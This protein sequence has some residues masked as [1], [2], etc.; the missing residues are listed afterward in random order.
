MSALKRLGALGCVGLIA[1]T[2][3]CS[4]KSSGPVAGAPDVVIRVGSANAY[5][6]LD[7]AHAY[8]NGAWTVYYNVYQRLLSYRPGANLP[9]EDAAKS[10]V[11]TDAGDLTYKCVLRP[12]M[13][14]WN[15]DPLDAAAVKYSIDRV[16]KINDQNG[17]VAILSSTIKS[18]E[19]QGSD[20]VLFHLKDPDATMPDRLSSGVASIIDPKTLPAT[21]EAAPDF[22]GVV[23]SGRYKID[24]VDFTGSGA[25]KAPS[26]MKLSL[27]PNYQG[28]DTPPRNSGVDVKYFPDQTGTKKALDANQVDAVIA[29]LNTS[30]VIHMQ[31]TQQL[32]SGL[33]VAS[34]PGGGINMMAL[35]T[36]SGVFAKPAV[37]RAVAQLIDR[38]A[39]VGQAFNYTVSPAYTIVPSGIT[40]ATSAFFSDYGRQPTSATKVREQLAKAG[41]T[42]PISFTFAYYS[43][44]D[45][46]IQREAEMVKQQ[47]ETGGLFKVTLRDY[48]TYPKLSDAILKKP[49]FDAYMLTWYSDYLDIDDYVS[50]LAGP[51]NFV[52]NGYSVPA[53]LVASGLSQTKREDARK[54]YTQIQQDVAKDVPLVPIWESQQYAAMQ[55]DVTGVPLTMDTSGIQRWWM[56]G[57]DSTS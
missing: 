51:H 1:A 28:S 42:Q 38:A 22:T 47:L 55:S 48:E 49:D 31:Q 4:S 57:K 36:T 43:K 29:D 52:F 19:T 30:D 8:D 27:N 3:A 56:I 25:D 46:A 14:F 20:T 35:N 10:C 54:D 13:K 11:Y 50:P 32:R 45:P 44:G 40:N 24:S 37:R 39:I 26:E 6:T 17:P 41:V 12:G 5:T 7:P 53:G 15:G 9:Q 2:C 23:G 18:V 34:G 21:T 33:Q 16:I